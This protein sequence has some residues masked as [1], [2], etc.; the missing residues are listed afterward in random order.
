M[1]HARQ[2]EFLGVTARSRN[3]ASARTAAHGYWR[4]LGTRSARFTRS[5][6]VPSTPASTEDGGPPYLV[7][8]PDGHESVIFPGTDCTV[9]RST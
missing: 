7:R 6:A 2:V 3:V 4:R 5:D 1:Q 9:E 8:Y